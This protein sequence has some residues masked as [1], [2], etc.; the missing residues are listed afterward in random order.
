MPNLTETR[1][2]LSS[3]NPAFDALLRKMAAIHAAKNHDYARPEVKDYYAN[4][5]ECEAF[6]IPAYKGI[7]IRMS[8]K[9]SRI[10]GLSMKEAAVKDESI[11]DTMLDLAN[12]ALLYLC[13]KQH[14]TPDRVD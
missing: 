2:E 12:Y 11:E 14:A 9:W 6:G 5:R 7:L 3:G 13:V 10:K 1:L 4:F 8:D